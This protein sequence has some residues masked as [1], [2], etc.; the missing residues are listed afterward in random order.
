MLNALG[1]ILGHLRLEP[2]HEQRPQA[3]AKAAAGNGA[4]G[5]RLIAVTGRLVGLVEF[6]CTAQIVGL[7]K[8]HDTPQVKQPI[9]QGRSGKRQPML[10]LHLLDALG[11]LCARILDEL[12]LVED[13]RAEIKFLQFLQV[14]PQ[15][16]IV[17][18]DNVVLRNLLAQA[19]PCRAALEH[20]HLHSRREFLRLT[21]P[22]VHHRCRANDQARLGLAAVVLLEPRQPGEGLQGFPQAHVVGKNAAKPKGLQVAEE[23]KSIHLIR[24]QVGVELVGQFGFWKPIK[25]RDSL[26]QLLCLGRFAEAL[27]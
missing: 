3:G 2:A 11:D 22:V 4:V 8:I 1:Q 14:S 20:Q 19:V 16:R 15:Q 9:L 23:I 12:G 21:P 6:L 5:N 17:G 25:F 24:S 26:A 27:D 13:Q 10:A 7:H 18:D